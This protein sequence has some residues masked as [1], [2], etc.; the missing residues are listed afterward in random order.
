M[1]AAER[2]EE[3]IFE[4]KVSVILVEGLRRELFSQ[5]EIRALK[6]D[7]TVGEGDP[8]AYVFLS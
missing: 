4:L 1:N 5:T 3:Q 2:A 7:A 8:E 6:L